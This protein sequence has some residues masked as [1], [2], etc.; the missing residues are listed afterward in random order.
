MQRVIGRRLASRP[1]WAA[2]QADPGLE[3]LHRGRHGGRIHPRAWQVEDDAGQADREL[4]RWGGTG[5]SPVLLRIQHREVLGP[6]TLVQQPGDELL[7]DGDIPLGLPDQGVRVG[8]QIGAQVGDHP[9]QLP[10]VAHQ[11]RVLV[12]AA[13]LDQLIDGAALHE[14][15]QVVPAHRH[16]PPRR[17]QALLR[18]HPAGPAGA[19]LLP[20]PVQQGDQFIHT[21]ALRQPLHDHD[22]RRAGQVEHVPLLEAL[23]EALRAACPCSR[24]GVC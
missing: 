11:R 12:V 3:R 15:Q 19:H 13:F 10:H 16:H 24:T 8:V 14:A 18:N 5:G 21:A 4:G 7:P 20:G 6:R 2:P 23:T 9:G 22:P 17:P 1:R